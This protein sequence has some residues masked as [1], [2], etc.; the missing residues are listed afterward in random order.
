[1]KHTLGALIILSNLAAA[2]REELAGT[3][4]HDAQGWTLVILGGLASLGT[5]TALYRINPIPSNN[6]SN[7]SPTPPV[8][9][10]S[11]PVAH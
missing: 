6:E 8:I 10:P 2:L 4:P 11:V 3:W 1:M 5:A 9:P 7:P